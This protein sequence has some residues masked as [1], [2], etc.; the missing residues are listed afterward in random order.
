MPLPEPARVGSEPVASELVPASAE[1]ELESERVAS[2]LP[3][4]PL[5]FE[6]E[7]VVLVWVPVESAPGRHTQTKIQPKWIQSSNA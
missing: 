7:P 2:G 1:R 5:E 4:A 3:L 6:S